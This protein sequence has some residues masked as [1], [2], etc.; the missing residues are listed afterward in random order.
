MTDEDRIR[1]A[2][3]NGRLMLGPKE[4]QRCARHPRRWEI[5]RWT[6]PLGGAP[7]HGEPECVRSCATCADEEP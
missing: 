3:S 4:R 6:W 2:V 1:L 5:Y 7:D